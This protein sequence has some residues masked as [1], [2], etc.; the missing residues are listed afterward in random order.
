M[1]TVW[2]ACTVGDDDEIAVDSLGASRE[3][4]IDEIKLRHPEAIAWLLDEDGD[5]RGTFV[6]QAFSRLTGALLPERNY[7]FFRYWAFTEWPVLQ[8]KAGGQVEQADTKPT[9][10]T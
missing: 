3:V 5:L 2:V 7:P 10:P 1:S 8:A 6:M 4:L 9:V